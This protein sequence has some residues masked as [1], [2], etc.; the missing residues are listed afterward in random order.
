MLGILLDASDKMFTSIRSVII[1]ATCLCTTLALNILGANVPENSCFEQTLNEIVKDE[2]SVI[3]SW[4][5]RIS[6]SVKDEILKPFMG[7]IDFIIMDWSSE[8]SINWRILRNPVTVFLVASNKKDIK[9]G[10]LSLLNKNVWRSNSKFIILYMDGSGN[11][12][13]STNDGFIKNIFKRFANLNALNVRVIYNCNDG[14][15]EFTWFPYEDGNCEQINHV[16]LISE[17][18]FGIYQDY[19]ENVDAIRLSSIC[20]ITAA[21]QPMEPYSFYSISSGFSKGI[22]VF[23]MREF[24]NRL[25]FHLEFQ[26]MDESNG[27]IRDQFHKK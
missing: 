3:I 20:E 4:S 7:K 22:E 1:L 6:D 2:K 10:I 5:H 18:E 15:G 11:N 27:T 12:K 25:K 14:I 9:K 16:R 21:I 17:C 24:A 23:L 8:I 26:P 19:S 13:R